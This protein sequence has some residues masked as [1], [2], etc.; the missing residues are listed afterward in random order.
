MR[1][2]P[3]ILISD[4]HG[5]IQALQAFDEEIHKRFAEPEKLPLVHCGDI[6]DYGA[7]PAACIAL[8]KKYHVV[9][10]VIGNHDEAILKNSHDPR[11]DTPHGKLA[12]EITRKLIDQKMIEEL[13]GS[14]KAV[15]TY[16]DII[17]FHGSI[18]DV[19]ENLYEGSADISEKFGEYQNKV[20]VFGHSHLQFTFEK[21][22]NLFINPGSIGQ[23]RN[24]C[25]KCQFGILYPD[26]EVE[27]IR[28]DYDIDGAAQSILK[29]GYPKFLATRLYLGI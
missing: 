14:M 2:K 1:D 19:W 24:A 28:V 16:E 29:R 23:P 12:L 6:L 21:G 15:D 17:A 22:G 10:S 13:N 3:V 8:L 4:I 7:D 5:N 18:D 25:P 9:A 20:F 11:F 26:N 27:L